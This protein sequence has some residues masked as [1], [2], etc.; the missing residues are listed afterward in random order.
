MDRL[1]H[2]EQWR[3][4][5][6]SDRRAGSGVMK[7]LTLQSRASLREEVFKM[8]SDGR[9]GW[10]AEGAAEERLLH[11]KL[12]EEYLVSRSEYEI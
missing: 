2:A 12:L 11:F 7:L 5:Y 10:K 4:I 1:G 6:L 9:K 8:T 3:T